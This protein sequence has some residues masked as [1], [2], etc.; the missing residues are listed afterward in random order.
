MA[1]IIKQGFEARIDAYDLSDWPK[2]PYEKDTENYKLWQHGYD[3]ACAA[4]EAMWI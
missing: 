1:P 2:N 4:L 3:E